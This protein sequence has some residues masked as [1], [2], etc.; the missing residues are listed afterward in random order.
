MRA[1][2]AIAVAGA[3]G[4]LVRHSIQKVV[5]RTG[6]FPWGTFAVNISGTLLIGLLAKLVARRF[7]VPMWVQ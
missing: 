3:F 1:T 2:L 4:V 5:P 6:G 7:S